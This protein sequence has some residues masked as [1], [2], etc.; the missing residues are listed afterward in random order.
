MKRYKRRSYLDLVLLCVAVV[1][2]V[3]VG[4]GIINR[5]D[6]T[7]NN[8]KSSST[9]D[10]ANVA[11]SSAGADAA[12]NTAFGWTGDGESAAGDAAASGEEVAASGDELA[13]LEEIDRPE[14]SAPA[15]SLTGTFAR[16][17]AI[18]NVNV[19]TGPSLD[20]G[21][22]IAI[23]DETQVEVLRRSVDTQWIRVKL[24]DG[25]EGWIYGEL[26]E[27]RS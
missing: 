16:V 6:I 1:L 8:D 18:M 9:G 12:G 17:R 21:V 5:G 22:I 26:L 10:T 2:L 14:D 7:G 25:R 23:P 4:Y 24:F 20:Y 13:T 3:I 19:R 15:W 11:A 27:L